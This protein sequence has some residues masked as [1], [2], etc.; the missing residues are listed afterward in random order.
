M[1]ATSVDSPT[2]SLDSAQQAPQ[3]LPQEMKWVT[4]PGRYF[5]VEFA[6]KGPDI[7]Y[8]FWPHKGEKDFPPEFGTDLEKGFVA[9]LPPNADVR[10]EFTSAAEAAAFLRYGQHAGDLSAPQPT[11][12]VCVK[13]MAN[14]PMSDRFLRNEVFLR[15]ETAVKERY[16]DDAGKEPGHPNPVGPVPQGDRNRTGHRR[17][18]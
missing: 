11:Y 12:W 8:H 9:V 6:D 3:P 1:Q 4:R 18:R 15:I 14:G 7:V 17:R 10:A 2:P 13:D 5:D 16:P